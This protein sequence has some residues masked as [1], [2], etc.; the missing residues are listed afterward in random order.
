ML[1]EIDD[2]PRSRVPGMI[3]GL[4]V[5]APFAAILLMWF[6]PT[7]VGAILGGA[8]NIDRRLNLESDYMQTVCGEAL[9]LGRD[10]AMCQCALATE[11]PSLDCQ[12]PFL[13]WS[14]A[15]QV[16][17]CSDEAPREAAVS[18]CACVDAVSEAMAAVE[19]DE[20]GTKAQAYR[21]CQALEDAAFLPTIE[22]LTPTS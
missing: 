21:N 17:Y 2:P 14:V 3:L 12:G 19:P 16:E 15:R 11:H 7:V 18:F 9:D 6:I 13:I 20:R 8:E 4:I 5:A 1:A 10:E 22:Q